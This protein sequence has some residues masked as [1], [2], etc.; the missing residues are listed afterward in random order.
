MQTTLFL[1]LGGLLM[2]GLVIAGI[3]LTLT[4]LRKDLRQRK[5][6]YRR[7]SRRPESAAS[8]PGPPPGV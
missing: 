8:P 7:R 5:R 6:R 1:V 2:V 4:G 3:T